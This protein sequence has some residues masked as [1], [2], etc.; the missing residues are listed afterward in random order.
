MELLELFQG[1]YHIDNPAVLRRLRDTVQVCRLKKGEVYLHEGE[2]QSRV[3]LLWSGIVR[4][5]YTDVNGSEH[6]DCF[7]ARRGAPA[8]PPCGLY[9]PS[10]I[11]LMTL[12][13]ASLRSCRSTT[14]L[15][16]S[17]NRPTSCTCTAI[18]SS[19]PC[20]CTTASKITLCNYS[21]KQ[22]YDWFLQEYPGLIFDVNNRYIASF[23]NM[24][25]ETLSRLR[26]ADRKAGPTAGAPDGEKA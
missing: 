6:T 3:M 24:T 23:L 12:T 9:D 25:P 19:P 5:Y 2:R 8:M 7:C 13:D 20:S 10:P 14:R 16:L 22:K 4:G 15:I 18:C 17:M 11:N 1:V 21:A 26:A